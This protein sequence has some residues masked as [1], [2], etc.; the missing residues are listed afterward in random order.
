MTLSKKGDIK[1]VMGFILAAIVFVI[2]VFFLSG[3]TITFGKAITKD[4]VADLG[5]RCTT[6]YLQ[7]LPG[8]K[9]S[10][11]PAVCDKEGKQ[12]CCVSATAI[13]P[14]ELCKGKVPGASCGIAKDY[15]V[16]SDSFQCIPKCEYCDIK[17]NDRICQNIV[18]DRGKTIDFGQDFSCSCTL[19][20]C[21]AKQN[22]GKCVKK[23]CPG[24]TYCCAP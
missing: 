8:E 11:V 24:S 1:V 12:T 21:D 4:C 3:G 13:A 7:C 9:V 16:C 5:G 10:L 20:Q 23:F 17:P 15:K 6:T 2:V 22:D 14:D 18:N 19:T